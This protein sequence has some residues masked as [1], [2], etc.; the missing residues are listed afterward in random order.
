[1]SAEDRALFAVKQHPSYYDPD[2]GQSTPSLP[3]IAPEPNGDDRLY[4]LKK[5]A[6]YSY[7]TPNEPV[8]TV[9]TVDHQQR[10]K[11]WD[12]IKAAWEPGTS[13]GDTAAKLNLS[14][15]VAPSAGGRPNVTHNFS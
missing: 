14:H 5:P 9:P 6:A 15:V 10:A 3:N 11:D 8:P 4:A 12:R 1:M 2:P 7:S 13:L